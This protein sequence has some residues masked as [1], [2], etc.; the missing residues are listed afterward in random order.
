MHR[1][2][3]FW[4]FLVAAVSGSAGTLFKGAATLQGID[5]WRVLTRYISQGRD[6]RIETLR[7]EMEIAIAKPVVSLE[8][9][10]EGLQI[11]MYNLGQS[12]S[13][14]TAANSCS[15]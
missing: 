5:A 1:D 10:E 13:M 14:G 2:G 15:T 9:M 7:R 11:I 6:I 3:Q 12:R 8:Q 4:G